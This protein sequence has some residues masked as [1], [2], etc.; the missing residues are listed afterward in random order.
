MNL[1]LD[2]FGVRVLILV[3]ALVFLIR[4]LEEHVGDI[5]E[6]DRVFEPLILLEL[7]KALP[8]LPLQ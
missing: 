2:P 6:H 5:V 3:V 4:L 1:G 7:M 8:L